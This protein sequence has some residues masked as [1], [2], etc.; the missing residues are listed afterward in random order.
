MEPTSDQTQASNRTP[1]NDKLNNRLYLLYV[2][3]AFVLAAISQGHNAVLLT[4]AGIF[5]LAAAINAFV[6]Q[7]WLMFAAP[8]FA[9]VVVVLVTTGV[10]K[11]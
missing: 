8:A 6:R 4:I 9:V 2:V 5:A 11:I 10:W 1:N 7:K 3:V